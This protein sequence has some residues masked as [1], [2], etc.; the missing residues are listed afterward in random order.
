MGWQKSS[1]RMIELFDH[2][3]SAHPD[4]ERRTMFG[5]PTGFAN[6]NLFLGL[7]EDRFFIRLSDSDSAVLIKESG[8]APFEPIPGR[9]S[10]ATLIVPARIAAQPALFRHWCDKA[11]AHALSLPPKKAK[12]ATKA[13]AAAKPKRAKARTHVKT[14]RRSRSGKG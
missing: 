12:K 13:K 1:E 9:K 7:H 11:L 8:A 6:G 3:L 5:C 4:V 2:L 10:R 14:P